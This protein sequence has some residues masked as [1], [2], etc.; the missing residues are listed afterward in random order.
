MNKQIWIKE[1]AGYLKAQNVEDIDEILL[2]YDEHFT[3]KAADGYTEEEIAVK[4]GDAKDISAQ[5]A[6]VKQK[7]DP[8]KAGRAVLAIGLGF[9]DIFVFSFF[10]V[11]FSWIIVLGISTLAFALAGIGLIVSPLLPSLIVIP[12]MPYPGAVILSISIL[13]FAA[14]LAV[15]TQYSWV[16]TVQMIRAYRRWHKNTLSDAKYPPLDV[17]PTLKDKTRRRLR[18]VALIALVV[19]GASFVIGYVVLAACAGAFEFWHVWNWFV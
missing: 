14:L 15:V 16:L 8:K 1:L 19:F 18:T 10:I 17:H 11:L 13:A 9:A 12:P 6:A 7:T 3:R 4:L 5:F 2:E